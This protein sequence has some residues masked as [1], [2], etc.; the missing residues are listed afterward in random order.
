MLKDEHYCAALGA[1]WK[2]HRRLRVIVKLCDV[3]GLPSTPNV[4]ELI[5]RSSGAS[6]LDGKRGLSRPAPIFRAAH[7]GATRAE[8]LNLN[9]RLH[10]KLTIHVS[11]GAV[12]CPGRRDSMRGPSTC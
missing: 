12:L 2:R 6:L 8:Q 5:G 7:S 10:G 4:L 3:V 11:T 1:N 9:A